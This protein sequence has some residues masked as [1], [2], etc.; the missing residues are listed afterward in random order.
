[1]SDRA[2]MV[3]VCL[4]V[5]VVLSGVAVT[6][7]WWTSYKCESRWKLS[8]MRAEY[9]IVNGCMLEVAPGKVIPQDSYRE[10]PQ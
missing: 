8:G 3:I 7:Y 6:G 4:F 10:I 9:N 1:M 2:A 5:S